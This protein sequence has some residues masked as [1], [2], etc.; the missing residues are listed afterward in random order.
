MTRKE[1]Q[2]LASKQREVI[3]DSRASLREWIF[4]SDDFSPHERADTYR[5][6]LETDI[7]PLIEV[8]RLFVEGKLVK[9]YK[10][11]WNMDT[12]V[13]DQ[14]IDEIYDAFCDAFESALKETQLPE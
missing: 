11:A 4:K 5:E 6:F 1:R 2:A 3:R 7:N 12:V 14:I 9:G 13:R 8:T 10:L